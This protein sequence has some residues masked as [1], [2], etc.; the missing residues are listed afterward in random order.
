TV[1][2]KP[3]ANA[4]VL[5]SETRVITNA[6]GEYVA[7]G[8]AAGRHVVTVDQRLFPRL[9]SSYAQRMYAEG[10]EP[11]IAD[12][13]RSRT[14]TV[15]LALTA[16]PIVRG[17]VV[18]HEGKPV[19]RARV[20]LIIA[21]R[22]ALDFALEPNAPRTAPDGRYAF[23]APEWNESE[24]VSVAVT[25]LLQST[26]RSKP[27]TLGK[28]DRTVDITLPKLETV[29]IR[30]LDR[31][32]KPVSGARVAFA[33]S[34]E[35]ASSEML[36]YI[37]QTWTGASLTNAEG[38][39]VTQLALQTYEF[40]AAAKGF[41]TGSVTK[42][43]TK[44]GTVDIPLERAAA[45]RGRLHRGDKGV[46]SVHVQVIGGARSSDN[47]ST[48]TDQDGK[49]ELQ[50]LAPGTYRIIFFK[51][52]E[53]IDRTM[54]TEA[55][56]EMDVDL[57]IT[58]KLRGRV[59]DSATGEPIRDFA[60]SVDPMQPGLSGSVNSGYSSPDGTFTVEVPA[61]TYRVTAG[62]QNYASSRPVEARIL[63][64]QTTPLEIA[65]GR[66]ATIRGRVTDDG[67]LP[68]AGAE[69]VVMAA[70]LERLRRAAR[71]GPSQTQT[72]D[73]GTFT[74]TG[75]E[76]GE[77]TL[78]VRKQGYVPYRKTIQAEGSMSIDVT[79]TRG[80]TIRGVVM[81]GGKP[82][83][84]A[85]IG[86]SSPAIGGDH[87]SAVSDDDGRF[88][89]AGLIPARYS[90]TAFFEELHT[91]VRNVD[92]AQDRDVVLSL[93]AKTPGVIYGVVTGMPTGVGKYT[94]RVVMA[95]S[96]DGSAE[97]MIDDAGSYRIENAPTGA[98]SVSAVVEAS[99]R[100]ALAST[101]R[102][103]EVLPGQSL[104]VDLDLGGSVR[105]SGH[106]TVEGKGVSAEVSFS[107]EQGSMGS[108]RTRDDGSYELM[109]AAPGRYQ[110]YARAEQFEDRQ[111]TT[112]REIR[113][114]ET[115]DIDLRE[116]VFE[117]TV[118]D[119]LTRQPVE[120]A[121]V[122]LSPPAMASIVAEVQADATGHFRIATAAAGPVRIIVSAPGY[123]QRMVMASSS[124]SQYAFELSPAAEVRIRVLDETTGA[125]LDAQ[126]IFSDDTGILTMRPRR[127]GDGT[128]F[129]FSVAPG[130]YH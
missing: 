34:E 41:Q 72:A 60:A 16:A 99:A 125:P 20:Q 127:S 19:S 56:G 45:L 67:G 47:T 83:A 46:G 25:P 63:E 36:T 22:P 94:R 112:L 69:V 54:T 116:Q 113:G 120:G 84:G 59:I 87:Q 121:L 91:E 42:A 71:V 2:G 104:R 38:E 29:R 70:D 10:T 122:T 114:G 66:G 75:I 50:G 105:V 85:Q 3:L 126:L 74:A 123:A 24:P 53:L 64:N 52:E 17:R 92:P 43:I 86:A 77:A 88:T 76:P 62:A 98:V 103:V 48:S 110:I 32:G 89:L 117:G 96:D 40:A 12:L 27:F 31:A 130:K 108:A 26:F 5:V 44:P 51:Q 30:V 35:T 6:K 119:A 8:L 73:D 90:V 81:R 37:V 11:Y 82:L 80:L 101:R 129:V 23:A 118:V 9:R 61:G 1:D 95:Y 111:Y 7:K 49:F 79:V 115:I 107:S 21:S 102:E 78:N 68:V 57:P 33:P 28:T 100:T 97:G 14:A 55:P 13:R 106:V 58:G 4:P 109:L 65:L 93:D 18:D 128:T 39:V 124:S 15:D